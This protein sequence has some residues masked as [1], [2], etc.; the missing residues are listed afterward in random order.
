MSHGFASMTD[1]HA[2]LERYQ[3]PQNSK[4]KLVNE[5]QVGMLASLE[6]LSKAFRP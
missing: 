1:K 3:L 5:V 2:D 4:V 6:T